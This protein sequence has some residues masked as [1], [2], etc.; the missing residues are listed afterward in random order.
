MKGQSSG[1]NITGGLLVKPSCPGNARKEVK[2]MFAGQDLMILLAIAFFIFGAKKLPEI[3]SGLG[4]AMRGFKDAVDGVE[5]E[6][7]EAAPERPKPELLGRP[8][9]E[10]K[11]S[12]QSNSESFSNRI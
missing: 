1:Q 2:E 3:G 11:D 9:A 6:R 8:K 7:P 5:R 12:S 4:K 10:I